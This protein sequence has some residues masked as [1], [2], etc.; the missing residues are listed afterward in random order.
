MP[1][2]RNIKLVLLI[3][4]L[5]LLS[6]NVF[7]GNEDIARL[8]TFLEY[9]SGKLHNRLRGWLGSDSRQSRDAHRLYHLVQDFSRHCY[10]S[11]NSGLG[12][13]QQLSYKFMKVRNAFNNLQYSMHAES[14]LYQSFRLRGD[15]RR[16]ESRFYILK[17]S[18][19]HIEQASNIYRND[20]A[21]AEP[22]DY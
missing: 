14:R 19:Q 10:D 1:G 20:S 15:M 11:I 21:V 13:G 16:I 8:A 18:L 3:Y 2:I 9:E 6:A 22:K 4:M 5:S 7:A 17:N 12:A